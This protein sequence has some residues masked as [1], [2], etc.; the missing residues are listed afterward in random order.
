[1]WRGQALP[2]PDGPTCSVCTLSAH[3]E[4]ALILIYFHTSHQRFW[5][6]QPTQASGTC[7]FAVSVI[8]SAWF[9][10]DCWAAASG[11][12]HPA[13]CG[14]RWSRNTAVTIA[15]SFHRCWWLKVNVWSCMTLKVKVSEH[16]RG[17]HSCPTLWKDEEEDP[18]Y[19]HW[20]VG[21]FPPDGCRQMWLDHLMTN[22][23][24]VHNFHLAFYAFW[25]YI[26][27]MSY[28]PKDTLAI[29]SIVSC[30]C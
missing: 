9:D 21:W 26:R 19:T 17:P 18:S 24:W 10:K 28:C 12:W 13:H 30:L 4:A 25:W 11:L 6:K 5:A 7:T 15:C 8:A 16:W 22:T 2:L 3:C 14:I 20:R 23:L 27:F 29:M 1:M